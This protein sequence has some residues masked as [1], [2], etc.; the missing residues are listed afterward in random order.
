ME[1]TCFLSFYFVDIKTLKKLGRING[2]RCSNI[3]THCALRHS[4]AAAS[5]SW[6]Y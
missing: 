2:G 3:S 5:R 6:E 1:N 4:S